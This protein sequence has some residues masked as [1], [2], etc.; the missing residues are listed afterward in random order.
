MSF[1]KELLK[2]TPT[3]CSSEQDEYKG[4]EKET[5]ARRPHARR[6]PYKEKNQPCILFKPILS[7]VRQ[8]VGGCRQKF[9]KDLFCSFLM[10]RS[11]FLL[12][13][14]RRVLFM[15]PARVFCSA[16]LRRRGEVV[17]RN[18]KTCHDGCCRV[19]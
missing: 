11:F 13:G 6:R 8:D 7:H 5:S 10:R 16:S 3:C 4:Q 15:L 2:V 9:S 19:S 1:I 12:L 14:P 17:Q 18:L